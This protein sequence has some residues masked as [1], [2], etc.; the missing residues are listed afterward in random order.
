MTKTFTYLK[1]IKEPIQK[2]REYPYDLYLSMEDKEDFICIGE[3]S[4]FG[5]MGCSM[6]P[7]EF[8]SGKWDDYI[9]KFSAHWLKELI[10]KIGVDQIKQEEIIEYWKKHDV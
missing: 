8:I 7:K 1:R 5:S 10:E 6:N 9:E 3:G 2:D 4:G